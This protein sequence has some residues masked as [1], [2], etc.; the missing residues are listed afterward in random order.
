[1]K[2]LLASLIIVA[3]SAQA[4][5]ISSQV[6]WS[7][8]VSRL[9]DRHC[10][11]CHRDGGAAFSLTTFQQAQ[12]HSKDMAK[13][14]L[15]RRMPPFGAVKGFG[16]LRDDQSLT[17]EQIELVISWVQGGAPQ[18][19]AS[20]APKTPPPASVVKSE[21]KTGLEWSSASKRLDA[22]TTFIAIRPKTITGDSI[23]V[24]AER[25]DGTVQPLIWFYQSDPKAARTYY[26]RKPIH[27]PAGTK[28]V[29]SAP[30]A[31][32]SLLEPAR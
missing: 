26:F 5:D 18:G 12:A 9:L 24:V 25:P 29:A 23:R 7:R 11:S 16:D 3:A 15:D 4:H 28:I 14:V 8:E 22:D 32:V 21:P 20:L 30:D 1:M 10:T 2:S 13:A 6:T 17:Q 27:L 19:D 31:T